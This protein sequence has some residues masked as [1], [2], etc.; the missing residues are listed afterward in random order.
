MSVTNLGKRDYLV[1]RHAPFL[2]TGEWV[3]GEWV[4]ATTEEVTV[5]ANIQPSTFSYRTQV[6]PSGDREKE[7]INI[8]SNDWLN[9]ARTGLNALQA[10]IIIYRGAQWKI[11][12]SKP[13]GNFGQ[14]CEALAIKIDDTLTV[15]EV[16]SIGVII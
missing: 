9:T 7:A 13:Y 12:V 1:I 11:V 10:D 15:R 5:R 14:H 3:D 4:E 2:G 6:L 16:G 8:Y